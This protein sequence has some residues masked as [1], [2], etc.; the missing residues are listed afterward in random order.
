MVNDTAVHPAG[1]SDTRRPAEPIADDRESTHRTARRDRV[2]RASGEWPRAVVRV[3]FRRRRAD[4]HESQPDIGAHLC[5]GRRV[6]RDR[7]GPRR[8]RSV[9]AH[10]RQC[11][12]AAAELW[13]G[14]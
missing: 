12:R 6:H 8:L 10:D 5:D 11:L 2:F 7:H 4:I 9:G 1:R 14:P 13:C 3:G